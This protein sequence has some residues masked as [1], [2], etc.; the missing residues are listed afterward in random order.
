MRERS[1][2]AVWLMGFFSSTCLEASGSFSFVEC[3]VG[4][5]LT[6][7]SCEVERFSGLESLVLVLDPGL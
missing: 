3:S 7:E 6:R 1:A 2:E 4:A 5:S